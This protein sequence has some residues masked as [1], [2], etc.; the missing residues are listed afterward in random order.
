[1]TGPAIT[2]VDV[3]RAARGLVAS[4][5]AQPWGQ[6]GPSVYET[7]RLVR[8]A[9]WLTGHRE[10]IGY[11]RTTQLPDGG[12]G[13][14]DGYGLVPTLSATEAL[15]STVEGRAAAERGLAVL[16]RWLGNGSIRVPDT[17]GATLIVPALIGALNER[18]G[19]TFPL[20]PGMDPRCL[21]VAGPAAV[22]ATVSP[23]GPGTVGGSPAA[24]AAWLGERRGGPARRY[25]E[26]VAR[27][28]PVPCAAPVTVFE[29]AWVLGSLASAG[30]R[31]PVPAGMRVRLSAG[32]GPDGT[33]AGPGLPPDADTTAVVV[34]VLGAAPDVL[35]AYETPTHFCTWPG[36]DGFSTTVN[37]HV[38][39][40]FGGHPVRSPWYL[41][42]IAKVTGCLIGAQRA[43]GS[44]DDRWH[45][46]PYYATVCCAVALHRF[47]GP[48]AAPAVHRAVGWVLANQ[49]PDGSW[50][51]WRGT[52]EETAYALQTLLLT[53]TDHRIDRAVSEGYGYLR[54][55]AEEPDPPALWHDKDLYAPTA[56][57]RA[58]ILGALHCAQR[59]GRTKLINASHSVSVGPESRGLSHSR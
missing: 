58:A 12:W 11:L 10:R 48:G 52:A 51:R 46:S 14:P 29:R 59:I 4:L 8:L 37:A 44:W 21:E 41:A 16:D 43:D 26:T 28:G 36:E 56:I 40:A 9:P 5:L 13:A 22:H 35:W 27:T 50:G 45:A 18:T 23:A 49:R 3:E 20:P 57:I 1:M 19:R 24:T 30:I 34:S 6:V 7:G 32:L 15:L 17:P 39:E 25:L 2:G 42:T 55:V 54:G 31:V 38:L 53:R 33:P 47:G